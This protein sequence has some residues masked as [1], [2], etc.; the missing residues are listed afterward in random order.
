M[1]WLQLLS[2]ALLFSQALPVHAAGLE[3]FDFSG[4]VDEDRYKALASELRCLVCQNQSLADSD[5]GLANDLRVEVYKLMQQ[6]HSDAEVKDFLVAR[7]GDFV[8]Y[9]PPV[10]P[11]T[12]LVWYGPFALLLLGVFLLIKNIRQRSKQTRTAFSDE[13]QARLNALLGD[14]KGEAPRG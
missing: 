1:K 11:S 10:K 3:S 9:K 14:D 7:Y 12:W 2:V 6:G 13:E 4:V 8:L 5:A